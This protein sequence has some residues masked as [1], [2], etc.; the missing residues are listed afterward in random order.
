MNTTLTH[1]ERLANLQTGL[2]LKEELLSRERNCLKGSLDLMRWHERG[3]QG[4]LNLQSDIEQTDKRI[5][6]YSQSVTRL[7]AEI[8]QLNGMVVA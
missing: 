7:K 5:A 4:F 8:A 2:K 1:K 6:E 3:S